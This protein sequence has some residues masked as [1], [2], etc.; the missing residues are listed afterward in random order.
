MRIS[1]VTYIGAIILTISSS[2]SELLLDTNL[3]IFENGSSSIIRLGI[4]LVASMF[5]SAYR[6]QETEGNFFYFKFSALVVSA[7]KQMEYIKRAVRTGLSH[8]SRAMSSVW[9]TM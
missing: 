7:S 6:Q 5:E 3:K 2:R 8:R 9:C 4:N 1:I